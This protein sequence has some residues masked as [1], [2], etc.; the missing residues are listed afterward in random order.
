MSLILVALIAA[1]YAHYETKEII[2]YSVFVSTSSKIVIVVCLFWLLLILNGLIDKHIEKVVD[3]LRQNECTLVKEAALTEKER[4]Y[5]KY[6]TDIPV[7]ISEQQAI[8]LKQ[9]SKGK[10]AKEIGREMDI[11]YRTVEVYI[12]QLK[13]KLECDSSKD[14][15][16]IYLSS[17]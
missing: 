17:H 7:R 8:C 3:Y 10:T 12:A 9:L 13:E 16:N 2:N 4:T 6:K 14:L 15:I 5:F 1:F 11:S